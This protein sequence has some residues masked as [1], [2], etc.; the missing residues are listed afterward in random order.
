MNRD[1]RLVEHRLG[2]HH[3]VAASVA[4]VQTCILLPELDLCFDIGRC[5]VAAVHR[6]TVLIS[7][8]HVDHLGGLVHHVALRSMWRMAPSRVVVPR[9]ILPDVEALLAVWRRIARTPLPCELLGVEPEDQVALDRGVTVT[10]VEASHRVPTLA[11]LVERTRARLRRDLVGLAGSEI[12]ARHRAGEEVREPHTSLE[13]GFTAD[14]RAALL[15]REPRLMEVRLL[16]CECT[17]VDD[18]L[19][20][21]DDALAERADRTGHLRL[22]DLA[23]RADRFANEAVLLTHFSSRY[24]AARIREGIASLPAPLRDRVVPLICVP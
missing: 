15:D 3:V 7:H 2:G 19:C 23:V 9:D 24:S 13:V 10:A 18:P 8:G 11:W 1:P 14:T 6:R 12:A 5:P 16:V 22:Q 21:P 4:G 17:F 20:E